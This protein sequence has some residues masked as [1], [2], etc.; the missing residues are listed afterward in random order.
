MD[1]EKIISQ[2]DEEDE[3]EIKT[4]RIVVTETQSYEVYVEA[5]NEEEAEDI[6]LDTYGYD[7]DI[8]HTDASVVLIEEDS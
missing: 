3:V 5:E 1:N 8:F 6:A 4:Y 7:G 2:I